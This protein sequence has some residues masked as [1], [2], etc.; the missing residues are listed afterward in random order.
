MNDGHGGYVCSKCGTKVGFLS[1]ECPA[2]RQNDLI[3]KNQ[4]LQKEQIALQQNQIQNEKYR[5]RDEEFNRLKA[6]QAE[7]IY[8]TLENI[9]SKIERQTEEEI[10]ESFSEIIL[11][12]KSTK[13]EDLPVVFEEWCQSKIREHKKLTKSDWSEFCEG[14][15]EIYRNLLTN[16]IIAQ[17]DLAKELKIVKT[18]FEKHVSEAKAITDRV[19]QEEKEKKAKEEAIEAKAR[20]ERWEKAGLELQEKKEQEAKEK[21]ASKLMFRNGLLVVIPII[22]LLVY[23]GSKGQSGSNSTQSVKPTTVEENPQIQTDSNQ[24]KNDPTLPKCEGEYNKNTWTNCFGERKLSDGTSYKGWYLD[25]KAHGFGSYTFADGSSYGGSYE[26]GKRHGNGGEYLSDGTMTFYGAWVDGKR[27]GYGSEYSRDGKKT[28]SGNWVNGV[29]EQNSNSAT[30]DHG[31]KIDSSTNLRVNDIT[32]DLNDKTIV[33]DE[34]SRVTVIGKLNQY[35]T[36]E[37]S[38]RN[39][40]TCQPRSGAFNMGPLRLYGPSNVVNGLPVGKSV[41]IRGVVTDNGSN[42]CGLKNIEMIATINND[43]DG[44][45]PLDCDSNVNCNNQAEV[46]RKMQQRWARFSSKTAYSR[47]CLDAISRVRSINSYVWGEG[48]AYN[49]IGVCNME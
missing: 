49:Q 3:E 40:F 30:T 26:Y 10:K 2:C 23:L 45:E 36:F 16:F 11:I 41:Q 43:Y 34:L 24:D 6:A 28:L 22:L 37:L 12:I 42:F 7:E 9:V 21:A 46:I 29:L 31:K 25:G 19:K 14:R 33:G 27:H 8:Q 1:S 18:I 5:I 35:G 13:I 17:P 15:A 4:R 38:P 39:K 47:I 48:L 44:S 20:E 32:G